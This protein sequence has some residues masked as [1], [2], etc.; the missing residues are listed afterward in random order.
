MGF[1][2][3]SP[4]LNLGGVFWV[5][6]LYF[7][8]LFI[9]FVL[10]MIMN[11]MNFKDNTLSIKAKEELDAKRLQEKIRKSMIERMVKIQMK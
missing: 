4:I 1:E 11:Y 9:A 7:F 6:V 8:Q 5:I 10:K 2:T 3:Y